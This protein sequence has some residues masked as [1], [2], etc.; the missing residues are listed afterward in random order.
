MMVYSA[1]ATCSDICDRASPR[2]FCDAA[3][4]QSLIH[5][6]SWFLETILSNEQLHKHFVEN[7]VMKA[8]FN[9]AEHLSKLVI[10]TFLTSKFS[11]HAVD[12]LVNLI[13][14]LI[15]LQSLESFDHFLL[16]L[17]DIEKHFDSI[18]YEIPGV[19][20]HESRTVEGIIIKQ[21]FPDILLPPMHKMI[22]VTFDD[23]L[24]PASNVSLDCSDD[25]I[26][27]TKFLLEWIK[28]CHELSISL[29]CFL[30]K[31]LESFRGLCEENDVCLIDC[32]VQ[33]DVDY[34]CASLRLLPVCDVTEDLESCIGEVTLKEIEIGTQVFINLI[35]MS[36]LQS[37]SLLLSSPSPG[38]CSQYK[39]SVFN[40]LRVLKHWL[41]GC[42]MEVGADFKTMLVRGE[43]CFYVLLHNFLSDSESMRQIL[44]NVT[45]THEVSSKFK[46]I[47][48]IISS[49]LLVIPRSLYNNSCRAKDRSFRFFHYL[50]ELNELASK[51]LLEPTNFLIP[52]EPLACHIT[53]LHKVFSTVIQIL[54][55]D[56]LICSST[57]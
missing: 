13:L 15:G 42:G 37:T 28:R 32:L 41:S 21:S 43:A 12:I 47:H 2:C 49:M 44:S 11:S 24:L 30:G 23:A 18:V 3:Q 31:A 16:K 57:S 48:S 14:E 50:H 4:R 1:L 34:I 17:E 7:F 29:V 8:K 36:S 10:K 5:S 25:V 51:P 19:C 53:L 56:S 22:V 6:L 55:I 38:L 46:Q 35:P 52:L 39:A 20:L 40:S 26:Y 9:D 45:W 33:E 27:R 54:R